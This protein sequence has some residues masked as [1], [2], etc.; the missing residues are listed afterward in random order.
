MN[1][2]AYACIP[3]CIGAKSVQAHVCVLDS[4]RRPCTCAVRS[5]VPGGVSWPSDVASSGGF[6]Q[7]KTPGTRLQRLHE[8]GRVGPRGLAG[9]RV[10]SRSKRMGPALTII[11]VAHPVLPHGCNFHCQLAA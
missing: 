4:R 6:G 2:C 1:E 5:L 9:G 8:G 7:S 3:F 11:E 10:H